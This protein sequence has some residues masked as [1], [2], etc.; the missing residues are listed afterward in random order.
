[1]NSDPTRAQMRK[2]LIGIW[3][4][5]TCGERFNRRS[6]EQIFDLETAIYYFARDYYGG[7]WTNLYRALCASAYRPGASERGFDDQRMR[8]ECPLAF[9]L[10]CSLIRYFIKGRQS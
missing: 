3:P 9:D 2:Y 5:I 6:D 1:M 8:E 4:A 10:Y 7:Q